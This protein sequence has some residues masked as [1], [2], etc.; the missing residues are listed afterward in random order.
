MI[1]SNINTADPDEAFQTE[2]PYNP[3]DSFEGWD[4]ELPDSSKWS[5][6]GLDDGAALDYLRLHNGYLESKADNNIGSHTFKT[7]Y[8]IQGAFDIEVKWGRTPTTPDYPYWE[9]IFK[10]KFSSS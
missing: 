10:V 6:S 3:D 9:S 7:V 1:F 5:I 2:F 4:G 8:S